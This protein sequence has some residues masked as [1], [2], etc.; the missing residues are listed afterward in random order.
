VL[1]LA[2]EILVDEKDVHGSW[3]ERESSHAV[4]QKK[5]NP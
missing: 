4:A 3:S 5:F 1:E 2:R